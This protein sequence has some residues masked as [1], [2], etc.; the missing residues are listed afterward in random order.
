MKN[1]LDWF[2][3]RDGDTML[4]VGIII[5]LFFLLIVILIGNLTDK[6]YEYKNK[7]LEYHKSK[8]EELQKKGHSQ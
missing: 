5:F 4:G 2:E 3:K 6:H 7:E 8:Q 1:I